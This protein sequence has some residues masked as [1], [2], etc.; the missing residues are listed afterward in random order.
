MK[1]GN[2]VIRKIIHEKGFVFRVKA[3]K[4]QRK[5]LGMGLV[6]SSHMGGSNQVH[7]CITVYYPKTGQTYDIAENLMEVLCE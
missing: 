6:L 4:E 1:V 2:L 3:A 5:R 7:P